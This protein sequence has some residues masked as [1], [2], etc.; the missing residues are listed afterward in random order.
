MTKILAI[1]D[2]R[3]NLIVLHALLSDAFHDARIFL[4]QTG[5]EGIAMAREENPD[6][7][8]LDLV[9]PGMDGFE[10]CKRLKEDDFLKRIP[11]IILTAAKTETSNRVKALKLGAEAFLGKPLDES[12]LTA[13]VSSMIRIKKSEDR[14]RIENLRLEEVVKERTL[15]LLKELEDRKRAEADL[16]KS[17]A[18]L[19]KS[20]IAMLGVLEDL[21]SEISQ[22]QEIQKELIRAK[23]KAEASDRLKTAFMNNI[24]HEV[25]TPLNG[26]LGFGE[27]MTN[28]ELTREE[29]ELYLGILTSSSDRLLKTINDYMDIS[30]I[31]SGNLDV[32]YSS[33]SPE[34]LV[35]DIH[36]SVEDRLRAG[37]LNMV[38]SMPIMDGFLVCSDLELVKKLLLT[39]VDNAIKYSNQGDIEIGFQADKG[40]IEFFVKDNGIGISED[41]QIQ[42]FEHFMQEDCSH[43]RKFEGSG[44]GL[45]IAKGLVDL[46]KGRIWVESAKGTGST[47][48]VLLPI[49]QIVN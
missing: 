2:N 5:S 13:Q 38:L 3:D 10:T 15:D 9:M 16:K 14:V 48:R 28:E 11:I 7:I 34:T 17:F 33:F 39:L 18:D 42:I 41:K 25:R 4:V 26:I 40:G 46:L 21:K 30:L 12:E 27:L 24:S 23:E 22:R 45:S 49:N 37:R 8:L 20:K 43:S 19:E 31:V 1:D 36:K 6:V 47:F 44:L 35:N 32:D 29:K